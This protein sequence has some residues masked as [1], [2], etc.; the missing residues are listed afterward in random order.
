MKQSIVTIVITA[1]LMGWAASAAATLCW[2]DDFGGTIALE[3]PSLEKLSKPRFFAGEQFHPAFVC[4]QG[5]TVSPAFGSAFRDGNKVR[6]GVWTVHEGGAG[7]VTDVI[8]MVIDLKTEAG[9][10]ILRSMDGSIINVTW[11]PKRCP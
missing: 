5:V 6:L 7:C 3:I 2:D 9:T 8:D 1:V 10:G 4:Q 11:T